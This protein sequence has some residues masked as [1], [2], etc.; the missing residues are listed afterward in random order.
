[1]NVIALTNSCNFVLVSDCDFKRLSKHH[2]FQDAGYARSTKKINGKNFRMQ[3][4]I[5]RGENVHHRNENPLDNRRENL[6]GLTKGAHYAFHCAGEKN[7]AKRPEIKS[8]MI[9]SAIGKH[10]GEKN[11]QHKLTAE[12]VLAIR[13]QY[14]TSLWTLK[15]LGK[16]YG[17]AFT[18]IHWIVSGKH[19]RNI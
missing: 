15:Q 18:T 14:A 11:A 17:V 13:A 12:Q 4:L 6:V 16:K 5:K 10:V 7:A 3:Q 8:K 1:M 19:W 2:W 9:A